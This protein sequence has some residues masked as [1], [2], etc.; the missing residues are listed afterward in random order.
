MLDTRWWMLVASFYQHFGGRERLY[1]EKKRQAEL[2]SNN[3][4]Q[5]NWLYRVGCEMK[6]FSVVYHIR[7]YITF[8][9]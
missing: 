5:I 3:K 1:S 8:S 2:K 9:A 6:K 7:N 4:E